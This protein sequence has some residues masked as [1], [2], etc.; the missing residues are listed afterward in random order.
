[1]VLNFVKVFEQNLGQGLVCIAGACLGLSACLPSII[2]V[3]H[4]LSLE[5]NLRAY[6]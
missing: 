4:G 6:T 3:E 5:S 2:P 1:M